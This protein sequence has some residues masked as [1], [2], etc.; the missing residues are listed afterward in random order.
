MKRKTTLVSG[1]IVAF[2]A[3]SLYGECIEAATAIN[4]VT[5]CTSAKAVTQASKCTGWQYNVYSPTAYIES[6]PQ[7]TPGPTGYTDPEYEYRLGS[8]ITPTMGVKVCPTALVPGTSFTNSA[9]DPCPKNVLVSASTVIPTSSYA[10]ATSAGGIVVYQINAV[11]GVSVVAGSPFIPSPVPSGEYP[12]TSDPTP[13]ITALDSAGQYLYALYDTGYVTG[14]VVYS[15][16]MTNGVPDQ[17][18]TTGY[19]GGGCGGCDP[20]S[21]SMIATPQHVFVA[22]SCDDHDQLSCVGIWAT[23]NG[24][25]TRAFEIPAPDVVALPTVTYGAIAVDP[26]EQYLY[27]YLSSTGGTVSDTVA[28][29]G[30]NFASSSATLEKTI[31]QQGQLLLGAK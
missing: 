5:I 7:V 31:S 25:L 1:L 22:N 2:L 9:A 18:S 30:L 24:V 15:Y 6:Y 12:G 23:N 27:W 20:R 17:V 10:I 21:S 4:L 11:A 8:S 3:L 29:Y 26:Q 28:I 19:F 13:T 16:K 14:A